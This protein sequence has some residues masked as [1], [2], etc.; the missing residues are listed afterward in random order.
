MFSEENEKKTKKKYHQQQ[1]NTTHR[2]TFN[3][4]FVVVALN[5]KHKMYKTECTEPNQDILAQLHEKYRTSTS[6]CGGG[7]REAYDGAV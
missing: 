5:V 2:E 7:G 6:V 3:E 1:N 4:L